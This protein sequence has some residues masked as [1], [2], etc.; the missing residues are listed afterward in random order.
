[1]LT[2]NRFPIREY[3]KLAARKIGLLE[4]IEKINLNA[5]WLKLPSHIKMSD[6]FN[7]KHLVLDTDDSSDDDM[8]STTNSLK[9]E[10]D[11]VDRVANKF[12][13]NYGEEFLI[14]SKVKS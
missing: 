11:D 6:V 3:N 4:I 12:M 10:E 9:P 14:R 2:K 8:N 1:M 5:Y 13:K 7:V